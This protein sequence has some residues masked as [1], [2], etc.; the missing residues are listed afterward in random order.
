MAHLIWRVHSGLLVVWRRRLI[1]RRHAIHACAGEADNWHRSR[2]VWSLAWGH[3]AVEGAI[4][5][6]RLFPCLLMFPEDGH[7][8][9]GV[10][11]RTMLSRLHIN[12]QN[13][14]RESSKTWS[15]S[16][17]ELLQR[18]VESRISG[19]CFWMRQSKDL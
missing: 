11:N 3:I 4:L 10:F 17:S 8:D 18:N 2:H 12:R 16:A 15:R 1:M 7:C 14:F 13:Q 5:R 19:R 9:S 6:K